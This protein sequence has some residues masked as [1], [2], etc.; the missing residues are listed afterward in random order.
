MEFPQPCFTHIFLT[1][2][3]SKKLIFIR[4]KFSIFVHNYPPVYWLS[5]DVQSHQKGLE[6]GEQ[7]KLWGQKSGLAGL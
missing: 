7:N 3:I 2:R 5:T 4:E 1:L 6:I